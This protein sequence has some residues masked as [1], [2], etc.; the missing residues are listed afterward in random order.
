[1]SGARR[2]ARPGLQQARAGAPEPAVVWHEL[3]RD[4]HDA[5]LALWLELAGSCGGPVLDVGAG[6]GRVALA[7]AGAGIEVVAL[8]RDPV[9][10][11]E[12]QA[13]ATELP[14][15]TVTA[16]ARSFELPGASFP[17]VIAAN[18]VAKL[19]GD[20]GREAFL[21]R[22]RAVLAPAGIVV[23]TFQPEA[24]LREFEWH[25]GEWTPLPDV[26][27]RGGHVFCSQ[28]T[29]ARRRGASFEL[30]R[31]RE[32]VDPTGRLRRE[33]QR[34]TVDVL[35]VAELQQAGQR[36]GLRMVVR[37][38]LEPTTLDPGCEVVVLGA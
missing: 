17:L 29:A 38:H 31:R 15:T 36:A 7:L 10:L 33:W 5:D 1:M 11:A 32:H 24:T 26:V 37:R 25:D 21:K 34:A 28:P 19:G 30:V 6:T 27:E 4:G 2:A 3:E 22:A 35:D 20:S 14:L 23:L 18:V 13:R 8:D 9:L 16:D 12:L